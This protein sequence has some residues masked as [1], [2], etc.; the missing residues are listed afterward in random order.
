MVAQG[1]KRM[2][3][4]V[5]VEQAIKEKQGKVMHYREMVDKEC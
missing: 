3:V 1:L 2:P 5:A 4:V